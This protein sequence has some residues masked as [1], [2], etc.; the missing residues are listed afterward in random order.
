[1]YNFVG[2]TVL[3]SSVGFFL[4]VSPKGSTGWE[5]R[6]RVGMSPGGAPVASL[7]NYNDVV[8]RV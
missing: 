7:G 4:G 3:G 5:D 8:V 1:M 6:T 2:S